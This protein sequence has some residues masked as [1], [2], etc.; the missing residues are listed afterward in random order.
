MHAVR[1]RVPGVVR[2]HRLAPGDRARRSRRRPRPHPQRA[3]PVRDRL[4]AVHVLLDLHRGLPVRGAALEPRARDAGGRP[5]RAHAREGPAARLGARRVPPP[6]ELDEH[7]EQAKEVAAAENAA[8]AADPP[9]SGYVDGWTT[10]SA[11]SSWTAGA[12]D[13]RTRRCPRTSRHGCAP[14]SAEAAPRSAGASAQGGPGPGAGGRRP[15]QA[16]A[17]RAR[18][19]VVGAVRAAATQP[20]GAALRELDDHQR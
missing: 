7:A 4:L 17:R 1:P 14:T 15:R 5:P 13:G 6:P 10:R 16:R 3:R 12:G 20:V 11:T 2:L 8:A 19:A 18:H 9:A